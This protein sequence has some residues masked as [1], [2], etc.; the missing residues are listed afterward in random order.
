MAVLLED[1]QQGHIHGNNAYQKV[2]DDVRIRK[3]I[4][5]ICILNIWNEVLFLLKLWQRTGEFLGQ[6]EKGKTL[7]PTA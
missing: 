5:Q 6:C 1:H 3:V 4:K 7:S 2:L